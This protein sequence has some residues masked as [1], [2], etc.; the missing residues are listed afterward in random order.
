M[1]GANTSSSYKVSGD[2][3][4]G[5]YFLQ[6]A[7]SDFF[8]PESKFHVASYIFGDLLEFSVAFAEFY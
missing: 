8:S 2:H 3:S 5:T 1:H 7:A 4:F 6:M